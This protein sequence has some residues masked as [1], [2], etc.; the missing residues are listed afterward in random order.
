MLLWVSIALLTLVVTVVVAWPLLARRTAQSADSSQPFDDDLARR[1]AVFRDRRDEIGRER[2]AGRLSDSEADQAQADLLRQMADEL[3]ADAVAAQ[4]APARA[5]PT[6]QAGATPPGPAAPGRS[7]AALAIGL[8]LVVFLPLSAMLVYRIVGAPEIALAQ[9]DG[10]LAQLASSPQA[11][12]DAMVNELEIRLRRDPD[13]GEAWAVLAEA[14][15][16]VGHH[17]AAIEAFEKATALLPPN[18]RLLSDYAEST[19]LAAGGDFSGRPTELLE[20]ALAADPDDPKAI[21]LMGAARYRAGDLPQARV[22]L[23]RLMATLPPG[24]EDAAR[25]G[26][27]IARLDSELA[28]RGTDQAAQAPGSG[29]PGQ[30]SGPAS[31]PPASS[32]VSGEVRLAPA[33]VE[34]AGPGAT[35][36]VIARAAEGPRVPVAVLRLPIPALPYRF[37]LGDAN[38]MDPSRLLSTAGKLVLEARISQSGDAMRRAGDLVGEPVAASSDDTGVALLIDR[39]AE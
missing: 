11:Q 36:F 30:A 37:E 4:A 39:V 35:L 17:G 16:M 8:A 7:R 26:E 33:L 3:P 19:A 15:K 2:A 12:F 28:A 32:V 13:D 10:R 34:R 23:G 18:A 31:G 38:A 27:V 22:F 25:I 6:T 5:A 1:L 9:L 14:Y 20:R 24:S 29:S 21:A